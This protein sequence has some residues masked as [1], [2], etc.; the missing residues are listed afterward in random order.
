MKKK[1][2]SFLGEILNEN[3]L[4]VSSLGMCSALAITLT[5]ENSLMMGLS[6]LF[7]L[8]GSN[9]IVSLISKWVAEEIRIPAFIVVIAT[10]VTIL[11]LLMKTYVP[12]L[13]QA[14]GI[15]LPL[16][17]VNCIILGR[18]LSFASKNKIKASILDGL[19]AGLGFTFALILLGTVREVLGNN[20][21]T[22]MDKISPLTGY[23]AKYQILPVNDIIPNKLFLSPA[24]AFITLGLLIGIIKAIRNR[25]GKDELN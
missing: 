11:E 8:M 13:F 5:F 19:K 3:P 2:F 4:F 15:Y 22:F 20:Q 1:T 21:I 23:I 7:V 10:F 12:S 14:L 16:I 25:G 18:A 17:V 9:L 6:V 24:G